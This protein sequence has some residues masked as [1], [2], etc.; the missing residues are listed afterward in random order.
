MAMGIVSLSPLSFCLP[1]SHFPFPSHYSFLSSLIRPSLPPVVLRFRELNDRLVERSGL[2][3]AGQ[4]LETALAGLSA[5]PA[6]A[7]GCD[8]VG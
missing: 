3:T 6:A 5:E 2:E 7:H 4:A 1:Y 8:T